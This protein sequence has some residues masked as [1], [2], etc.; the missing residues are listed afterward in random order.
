MSFDRCL[1]DANHTESGGGGI[2]TQDM[3]LVID[4]SLFV[5][6]TANGS[7]GALRLEQGAWGS[8]LDVTNTSFVGNSANLALG[9][10]VMRRRR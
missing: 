3:D 8:T 10:A 4:A 9:G 1:F 5:D 2:Y 7:G 6:N